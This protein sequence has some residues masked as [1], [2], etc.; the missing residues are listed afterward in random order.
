MA[1]FI[2]NATALLIEITEEANCINC[3]GNL[4][5]EVSKILAEVQAKGG[6]LSISGEVAHA[7]NLSG[8]REVCIR[9][10][11]KDEVTLDLV[12]FIF[13]IDKGVYISRK[14]LFAGML[15]R[16]SGLW[17][18]GE[19]VKSGVHGDYFPYLFVIHYSMLL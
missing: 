15:L 12:E 4:L 10:V 13:K 16:V 18:K 7:I 9:R 14:L 8:L 1:G 3:N 17:T 5:L 11:D 6:P 19:T 2:C